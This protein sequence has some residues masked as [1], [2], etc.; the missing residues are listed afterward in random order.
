MA[1]HCFN[2]QPH[3]GGCIESY[4]ASL[5]DASVSTHSRTEAAAIS[6]FSLFVGLFVSTHSRTE[7]AA[8]ALPKGVLLH[9][10]LFQHTAARRR[11]PTAQY[12][13]LLPTI[14]FNTQPHGGGC[15]LRKNTVPCVRC[16]NTQPH[17]GGCESEC[18]GEYVPGR[19]NTQPHGGGCLRVANFRRPL[20]MFQH[21]AA[22]RR[23]LH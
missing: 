20:K 7:A 10:G 3:G 12:F 18:R 4:E 15:A 1:K 2:T 17:G 9:F 19:F 21:T 8:N 14:G 13:N 5:T 22:R 16:F 11:L 6:L 23:L